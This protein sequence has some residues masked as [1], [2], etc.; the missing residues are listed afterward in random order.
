MTCMWPQNDNAKTADDTW[1]LVNQVEQS[2]A[3][4]MPMPIA[5]GC[6]QDKTKQHTT[7]R[8]NTQVKLL[9]VCDTNTTDR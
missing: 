7:T 6:R 2:V 3:H 4:N 8:D 5:N 9:H 1:E